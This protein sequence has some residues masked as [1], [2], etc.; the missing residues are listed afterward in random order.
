[1]EIHTYPEMNQKIK[2]REI[3]KYYLCIVHGKPVPAEGT[4]S[5]I[6]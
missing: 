2:D 4:L 5:N 1:M 6:K 3:E